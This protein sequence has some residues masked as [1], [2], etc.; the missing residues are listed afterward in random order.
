VDPGAYS[1]AGSAVALKVTKRLIA[2]SGAYTISGYPAQLI[3]DSIWNVME[4]EA[5]DYPDEA[6]DEPTWTPAIASTAA[7]TPEPP[8]AGTWTNQEPA[9][10][11]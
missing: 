9:S 3:Y 8:N 10:W 5:P 6:P 11:P 2:V 7:Y 1:I 4:P